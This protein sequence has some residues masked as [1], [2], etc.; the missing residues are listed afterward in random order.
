MSVA[1]DLMEPDFDA[2]GLNDE[3]R[4][5]LDELDQDDDIVDH[6]EQGADDYTGVDG[7]PSAELATTA[8]PPS[9]PAAPD[10]FTTKP[11]MIIPVPHEVLP[12]TEPVVEEPVVDI[13]KQFEQLDEVVEEIL[14]GTRADR[15]ETQDAIN[16]MKGE[17]DKAI[18]N[19]AP[20]SRMFVDNLVT[21]LGVKATINMTAVKAMEVKAKML[22]ATKAGVN[23]QQNN[24]QNNQIIPGADPRLVELLT[25]NPLQTTGE[26]EF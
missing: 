16:L 1:D 24:L 4:H 23:I 6:L 25:D 2:E 22:A 11:H 5:L 7:N 15:Q 18:N 17:I 8:V 21:A 10:L 14:Q 20:P 9:E 19:N 3:M 26:D 13:R 12:A